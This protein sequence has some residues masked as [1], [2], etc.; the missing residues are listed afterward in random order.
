MAFIITRQHCHCYSSGF[1]P[2]TSTCHRC[3]QPIKKREFKQEKQSWSS[4]CGTTGSASW[5]HWD[6][7]L[8]PVPAQRVKDLELLQ[9]QL[10]IWSLVQ[11]LHMPQGSQK[12]KEKRKRKQSCKNIYK[13]LGVVIS[14]RERERERV[15]IV[16]Q[17][18]KSLS[19]IHEE[20]DSIPD[21]AHW[22]KD[23]A[24]PQAEA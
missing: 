6:M 15:P 7:G 21:L 13:T 10:R 2:R 20:A 4:F 22:V 8:C 17:W 14:E 16:A 9:L 11:E 3:G 18:V 12:W 1:A 23:P 5:E 24:L 19:C